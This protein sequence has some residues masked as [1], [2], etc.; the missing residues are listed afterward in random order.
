MYNNG[1][2]SVY[3]LTAHVVL[4]VEYRTK[5]INSNILANLK[6]LAGD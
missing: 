6:T 5:A 2:R 1:F 4:V 3:K